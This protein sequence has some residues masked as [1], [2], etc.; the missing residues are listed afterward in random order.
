MCPAGSRI[1]HSIGEARSV[2]FGHARTIF[3]IVYEFEISFFMG[4]AFYLHPS[5]SECCW[6]QQRTRSPDARAARMV[7]VGEAREA[8]TL[9]ECCRIE[10]V[11]VR[12]MMSANLI[13][14]RILLWQ[15]MA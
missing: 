6:Q 14:P 1:R 5:S 3:I 13:V 12:D 7:A 2:S 15:K 11:L 8:K 10:G 9:A 4:R